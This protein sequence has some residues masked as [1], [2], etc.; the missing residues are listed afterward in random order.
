MNTMQLTLSD[1]VTFLWKSAGYCAS[2]GL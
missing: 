2:C 1:C